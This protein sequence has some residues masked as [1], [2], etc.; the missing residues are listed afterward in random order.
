MTFGPQSTTSDVTRGLD[1]SGR[2]VVVTGGSGGLGFQT[3]RALAAAG[4]DVVL[5]DKDADRGARSVE[6]LR[7]AGFAAT[8]LVVDLTDHAAVRAAAAEL[9]ARR[10]RIDVLINNAGAVFG[11]RTLTSFGWEAT[12]ATNFL[13]HF[14]LTSALAPALSA[15]ARIVN[16][17][18]GAHRRSGIVWDDPHFAHRPYLPRDAYAQSKTAVALCTLGLEQR[19]G[20]SGVHAYTVRPGVVATGLYTDLTNEQQAAFSSRVASRD[21]GMSVERAAATTVWAA[22]APELGRFGGAYLSACAVVGTPSAPSTDGHA[23]WIFDRDQADRLWRL[24]EQAVGESFAGSPQRK[25]VG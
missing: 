13:G 10:P 24:A 22:T 11:S 9:I 18:S 20:E 2:C 3:A 15:T 1:L 7:S 21:A 6:Q 4:A 8:S 14:V 17:G 16:V 5:I 19:L 25:Q 23:P 12:L